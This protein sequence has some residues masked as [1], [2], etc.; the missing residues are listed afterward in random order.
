MNG[1]NNSVLD[2]TLPSNFFSFF[3]S[4]IKSQKK[5]SLFK[6]CFTTA[7]IFKQYLNGNKMARCILPLYT[8]DFLRH[9][10]LW[11]TYPSSIKYPQTTPLD[12]KNDGTLDCNCWIKCPFKYCS[13][14][15]LIFFM[16]HNQ[17]VFLFKNCFFP[18]NSELFRWPVKIQ[19]WIE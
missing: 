6:A 11:T 14:I 15:Y 12:H 7:H 17:I 2:G 3:K 10:S 4:I 8:L 19:F 13:S 18:F 5:K 1:D 16:W 9:V